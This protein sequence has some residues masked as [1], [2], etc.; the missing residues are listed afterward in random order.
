MD[1]VKALLSKDA[2]SV[3]LLAIVLMAVSLFL[4]VKKL[5]VPADGAKPADKLDSARVETLI[6]GL[7]ARIDRLS[8]TYD[9]HVE[10]MD[11]IRDRFI[12]LEGE[13]EATVEGLRSAQS[14][15]IARIEALSR[16]INAL[17]A[18]IVS[19]RRN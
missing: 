1:L 3:A 11:P 8:A 2:V 10:E 15:T 16:D 14:Q 19:N 4:L 5:L 9:D 18:T 13:L 7:S 12:R 6:A 17:I